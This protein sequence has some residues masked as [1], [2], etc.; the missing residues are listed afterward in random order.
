MMIVLTTAFSIYRLFGHFGI[1]HWGAVFTWLAL[2]MG[3]GVVWL[4]AYIRNWLLW[5][6]L[7]MNSSVTGLYTTF[8]VEST[9]CLFPPHYFWWT[10][11]GTSIVVLG[12]AGWIIYRQLGKLRLPRTTQWPAASRSVHLPVNWHSPARSRYTNE[13]A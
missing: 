11:V 4:R 8:I 13:R 12:L 1:V 6:Y 2:A 10:T 7:A 5:H 3:V 9:Y